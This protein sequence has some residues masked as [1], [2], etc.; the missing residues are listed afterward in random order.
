MKNT[1]YII[2]C[3]LILLF[4]A[5]N[6]K[7]DV[8][9]QNNVTP[10]QI[11][12]SADV[13]ALLFGAYTLWQSYGGFG[14]QFILVPDLL[15][16]DS[17]VNFIGTYQDYQAVQHKKT[18]STNSI[19]ANLWANSYNIINITNTVLD[20]LSIVDTADRATIEGE[21]KF[22]R[23]V[24]Y[25][26]LVGF[27][28]KP[29]SDGQASANPGVPIV[30]APTYAYD[31]LKNRPSR[32][33]VSQVYAQV[34]SDLQIAIAKLPS[35]NVN[36]RADQFSA[37][38][39][40]S[41]VYL[42]M[43]DYVNAALQANDVINSGNFTLTGSYDKAFNN[44]SNSSEDVF[45][46]QQSTQSNAG[47]SNQGLTTFYSPQP[48]GR[49]DAQIDPLYFNFFENA[50]FRGGN[51]TQGVSIAGYQGYYPNKWAKFYKAIPVV[52]LAEMYLTRGEANLLAGGAPA[53]GTSPV[54]DIN[55][56][57]MRSNASQLSTVTL[58][59][60]IDERMRELG[61]EGDRLWTLKRLQMDISGLGYDDNL[62]VLPIPQSEIDV[63]KNLVQNPG[64]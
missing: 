49:G 18:V 54:D 39:M 12:T 1:S 24:T 27:F 25:F 42:S 15:A 14:E 31:S 61:F 10:S 5:C 43:G 46:I 56:V 45:A 7:L 62:L 37:K 44:A 8:L 23:G 51:V 26:E 11:K 47:T 2:A 59:D 4:P 13:E 35:A 55:M 53:G 64:Y 29:Y 36:F 30:L 6:K 33:T 9:P 60:F 28:G 48:A 16:S 19:P 34:L 32:A 50:D 20:K 17:Q 38:A 52:R 3:C 40:L 22:I 21:A 41:R 63:N 57:R 58:Q